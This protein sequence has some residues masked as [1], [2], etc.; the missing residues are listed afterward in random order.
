[1]SL[2]GGGGGDVVPAGPLLQPVS[3]ATLMSST[4][5]NL[6]F[7]ARRWTKR[8]PF[9]IST[10]DQERPEIESSVDG[11]SNRTAGTS[12]FYRLGQFNMA[13]QYQLVHTIPASRPPKAATIR[14]SSD[15]PKGFRVS[16]KFRN[17]KT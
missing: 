12:V 15:K 2:T 6:Y 3:A 16:L 8:T 13:D 4:V 17:R 10:S 9:S 11:R 14:P 1:M 5:R 7:M